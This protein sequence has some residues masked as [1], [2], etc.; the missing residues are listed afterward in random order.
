[1]TNNN[2]FAPPAAEASKWTAKEDRA[3]AIGFA[4]GSLFGVLF[5]FDVL[6]LACCYFGW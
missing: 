6:G 3:F 2:P 1:M 4:E 5:C